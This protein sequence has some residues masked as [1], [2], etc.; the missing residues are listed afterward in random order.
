MDNWL[1]YAARGIISNG[2]FDAGQ[3]E[4]GLRIGLLPQIVLTPSAQ[5]PDIIYALCNYLQY[6][7]LTE[8]PLKIT[9]HG[10]G[11]FSDRDG[12]SSVYNSLDT[13]VELNKKAGKHLVSEVVFHAGAVHTF[14][15]EYRLRK[16]QNYDNIDA[17]FTPQEYLKTMEK[18]KTEI[19]RASEYASQNNIQLLIENVGQINFAVVPSQKLED[20]PEEFRSDPRW[21]DTIW[22]PKPLQLGN[23][24]CVYDLDHITTQECNLCIDIEHL[25]QSVEYSRKHNLKEKNTQVTPK[26]KELL[27]AHGIFVRKGYPILFKEAINPSEIIKSH[28]GRIKICHLGGQT[29]M[30][31]TDKGIKKI[32]SHMPITFG[33]QKNEYVTDPELR[34]HQNKQREKDLKLYLQALHEAGCRQGVFELHLGPI[35]TGPKWIEHHQISLGNVKGITDQL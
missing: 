23:I 15:E 22:L 20:K 3:I 24:G 28:S 32:G 33:D 25:N 2:K 21:G 8:I 6:K 29:S 9:S 30:V 4:E 13:I 35:Y 5:N 7:K 16:K 18:I 34:L 27:D 19:S 31:Y 17:T 12:I 26:E 11:E 14:Y 10:K 1:F